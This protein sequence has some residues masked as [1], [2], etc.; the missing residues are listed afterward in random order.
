MCGG[1]FKPIEHTV[2]GLFGRRNHEGSPLQH[3]VGLL[4]AA[5][6]LATGNPWLAGAAG[7]GVG[8]MN[9]GV[10]GA[11]VG[12]LGSGIG[13]WLGNAGA[14][15]GAQNPIALMMGKSNYVGAMTGLGATIGSGIASQFGKPIT[16]VPAPNGAP[17]NIPSFE[18]L[19]RNAVIQTQQAFD[20]EGV[21]HL[22]NPFRRFNR[23]I[24]PSDR[25]RFPSLTKTAKDRARKRMRHV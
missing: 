19:Q 25:G 23:D 9:G 4:P 12:G 17:I 10:R 8:A 15:R 2:G 11:V 21:Y 6:G 3:A 5:I 7:A 20:R 22:L 13:A 18:Q 24:A 1:I 16:S 14:F